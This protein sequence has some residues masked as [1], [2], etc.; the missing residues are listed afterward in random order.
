MNNSVI[1]VAFLIFY[2]FHAW[3]FDRYKEL[4]PTGEFLFLAGG[5]LAGLILIL[6]ISFVYF[7]RADRSIFRRMMPGA[8]SLDDYIAHLKPAEIPA[9]RVKVDKSGMVPG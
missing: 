7:F 8:K 3:N 5:F 6:A 2:F 4:I 9:K 1:P